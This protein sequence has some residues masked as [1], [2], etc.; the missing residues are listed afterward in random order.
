MAEKCFLKWNDFQSNIKA[1]FFDLRNDP[2]FADVTLACAD[3]QQL[4]VH[5]VILAS[6][7]S[8]FA[9]ILKKNKHSHPLIYMKG[10]RTMDLIS[11]MDFMYYGEVNILQDDL[12]DF[13]NL[14]EEINLRGLTVDPS[15]ETNN[16][17][18]EMY[19]RR[20]FGK[21]EPIVQNMIEEVED[22]NFDFD[23][24]TDTAVANIV[25]N[26]QEKVTATELK[27]KLESLMERQENGKWKCNVCGQ[28]SASGTKNELKKHVKAKHTDVVSYPCDICDKAY[29]LRYIMMNQISN[30]H[31]FLLLQVQVCYGKTSQQR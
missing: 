23:Y 12:D 20:Y 10:V 26:N 16:S 5:R 1:S 2:D 7:S 31:Y 24:K 30:C 11:V 9:N 29:R 4:E 19:R 6:S 3:G 18:I 28:K 15:S 22:D 27:E 14:A 21:I 13:L 8:F 17:S 25:F